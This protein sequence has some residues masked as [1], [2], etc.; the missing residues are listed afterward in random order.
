MKALGFLRPSWKP[1]VG[2]VVLTLITSGLNA[3]EPMV[4]KVL[5]DALTTNGRDLAQNLDITKVL[6]T[7][8]TIMAV[9]TIVRGAFGGW[10]NI[11]TWRLKL[12]SNRYM[13]DAAARTIYNQSLSY[14]RSARTGAVMSN[15]DRGVNGFSSALS[16]IM[17]TLMPNA[18]FL[19]CTFIFMLSM[20]VRLT[21]IALIFAPIPAGIS[22]ISGRLSAAR[23][24]KL[25]KYWADTYSRFQE[26]LVLAKTVKSF[27]LAKPEHERFMSSVDATHEMM[28]KGIFL[29]STLAFL[30]NRVMDAARL[31]VLGYGAYLVGKGEISIGT[32][33]AF[34]SY[35][36]SLFGPMLGLMGMYET[37]RK[38]QVYCDTVYDIIDEPNSVP[39][40]ANAK[41]LAKVSGSIEF[42]EVNFGY[43]PEQPVLKSMSFKV[44]P[45]SMIALV[46]AS[47]SG[48][49]TVVDLINRF[50]DPQSGRVLL[51]GT[52]LRDLKQDA[53][54]AQ[55]GMV[56][57][58][59]ALFNDTIA[60]NIA[61][62]KPDAS[63]E[64]IEAAA[65]AAAADLFIIR[66]PN[67]YETIVGERGGD[68]S[69]GER[70]RVAI[71]RA[72]LK[73]PQIYVFDEAS[74]NLDAESEE[75]ISNVIED[76]AKTKTVFVIAH[77]L[78]TVRHAN[79]ILVLDSGKICEQGTHD[80]LMA[81]RGQYY[82]LLS[83]QSPIM[84][85]EPCDHK[86]A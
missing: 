75:L 45:G 43:Q 78:A 22:V 74:S 35:T 26:G 18:L 14:H 42:D 59:T 79:Q 33:V 64:E 83:A 19:I 46:G 39:D 67:R 55:I 9:L 65:K 5:I 24:K 11:L 8:I 66:K 72:M 7:V 40:R 70:Q 29:D 28:S 31:C 4:Q 2:A 71:A 1:A 62:G 44:E 23:E 17:I 16:D 34:L 20:D 48:K 63:P 73:N 69:A 21:M 27:N 82:N 86:V 25:V 54:R 52:D 61:S 36:G 30:K 13:L 6:L 3:V 81:K 68:L 47:G 85:C 12:T 51:D 53:V 50:Y 57:Q 37:I 32:L 38:A 41:D 80:E 10:S 60:N 49:T 76:L 77:R 84:P 56:L 58:D 15:L